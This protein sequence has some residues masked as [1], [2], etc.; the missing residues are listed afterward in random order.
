M[1]QGCCS[2]EQGLR[3]NVIG[4]S[5]SNAQLVAIGDTAL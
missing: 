5:L 4:T 3:H 1:S 2:G